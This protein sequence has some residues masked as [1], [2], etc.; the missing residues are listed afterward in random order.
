MMK[1]KFRLENLE[2]ANCAAK[3]EDKISKLDGVEDVSVNFLTTKMIIEGEEDKMPSI[4]EEAK[5]II[6]DIESQVVVKKA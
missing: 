2:C 1:K 3:M 4:I 6:T 5:R